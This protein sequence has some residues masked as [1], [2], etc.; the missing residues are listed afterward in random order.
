MLLTNT[1]NSQ[2]DQLPCL[3]KKETV[4]LQ[5]FRA[6]SLWLQTGHKF[7]T[8][9]VTHA[10]LLYNNNKATRIKMKFHKL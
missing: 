4:F 10:M 3:S 1:I 9:L 5:N 6:T 2:P 7:Q 8:N